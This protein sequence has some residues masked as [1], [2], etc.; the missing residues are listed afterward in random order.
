MIEREALSPDAQRYLDG[1]PFGGELGAAE[2]ASADRLA[3]AARA[4]ADGLEVM[5]PALDDAV[6][7]VVRRRGAVSRR[8]AWRWLLTPQQVRL[9]PVWVAAL[10]AAAALVFWVAPRGPAGVQGADRRAAAA[11]LSPDTVFVRFEMSAPEAR[12]V[13]VAGS[14]TGWRTDALPMARSASGVWFITVP[15]PVGEHR[16]EFVV[17]GTRWIPD[18]TA[19]AQVDDGFGGRNSV[20]VVGPK[21]LVRS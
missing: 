7:A 14:F 17:D 16:Y 11:V 5:D 20:I 13:S 18:P 1:E 15:L 2:R 10:A 19:H 21:G 6:M 3:A 4:Y 12:S 9:R 8:A